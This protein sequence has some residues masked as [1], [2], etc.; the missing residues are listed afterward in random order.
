MPIGVVRS[1]RRLWRPLLLLLGILYLTFRG[2]SSKMKAIYHT[3]KATMEL[4]RKEHKE[5]LGEGYWHKKALEV[6]S[7]SRHPTKGFTG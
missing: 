3:N 7:W 2:I 5:S 1:V 6:L 4:Y